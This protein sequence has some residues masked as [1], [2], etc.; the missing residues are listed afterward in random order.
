MESFT[1]EESEDRLYAL[2]SEYLTRDNLQALPASQRSLMMLVGMFLYF[3]PTSNYA[4][5][6]EIAKRT[7]GDSVPYE[8]YIAL[9]T[10]RN[11][12]VPW[13]A[14]QTDLLAEDWKTVE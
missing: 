8:A 10:V 13:L 1:P 11:S 2:V 7:F 4:A 9:K 12:V 14:S 6:T 3:V 5:Q